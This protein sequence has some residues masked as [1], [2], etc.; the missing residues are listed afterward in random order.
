MNLHLFNAMLLIMAI[1]IFA[2]FA[3]LI[4]KERN[5]IILEKK[6]YKL[7]ILSDVDIEMVVKQ[8]QFLE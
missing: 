3:I 7:T 5:E 6:I 1:G 2:K 4:K 8:L